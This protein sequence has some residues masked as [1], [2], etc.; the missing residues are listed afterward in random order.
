MSIPGLNFA[1]GRSL[2]MLLGIHVRIWMSLF[3]KRIFFFF[4][5]NKFILK[6][7]EKPTAFISST[8]SLLSD[9][10]EMYPWQGW[11]F[12][13]GHRNYHSSVLKEVKLPRARIASLN[14]RLAIQPWAGSQ[15]EW[16]GP[17]EASHNGDAW[18]DA[19]CSSGWGNKKTSEEEG[20]SYRYDIMG[21]SW[22]SSIMTLTDITANNSQKPWDVTY[23]LQRV[24]P[25]G[26][27]TFVHPATSAFL[28]DGMRRPGK[29]SAHPTAMLAKAGFIIITEPNHHSGHIHLVTGSDNQSRTRV[30]M[31]PDVAGSHKLG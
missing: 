30:L 28:P 19:I 6:W 21:K 5:K 16:P 27:S 18:V 31:T 4:L 15:E 3:T 26:I 25:S 24:R 11:K 20:I 9:L 22:K 8:D 10:N 1:T 2:H 29:D 12:L 23:R 17:P 13:N 14:W 7:I